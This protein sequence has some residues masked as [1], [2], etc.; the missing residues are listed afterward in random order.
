MARESIDISKLTEISPT[1]IIE[2]LVKENSDLR[3]KLSVSQ[4]VISKMVDYIQN[5]AESDPGMYEETDTDF[6]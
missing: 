2:E 6:K 4:K 5:S 3:L 1:E